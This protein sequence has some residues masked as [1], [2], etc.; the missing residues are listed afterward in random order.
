MKAKHAIVITVLVSGMP[1]LAD[2]AV[3]VGR[4]NS[5]LAAIGQ[6][7]IG[8][9]SRLEIKDRTAVS[10]RAA[11]VQERTVMAPVEP[12]SVGSRYNSK[13]AA[14]GYQGTEPV[15]EIAP[16]APAKECAPDCAAPCCVK[17]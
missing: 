14:R 5:R 4:Y 15:F 17:N 16:L 11:V 10:S 2:T 8:T 7:R 6:N 13:L 1:G 9:D 12:S 3:D